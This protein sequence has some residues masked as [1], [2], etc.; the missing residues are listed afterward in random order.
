[1]PQRKRLRRAASGLLLMLAL[2]LGSSAVVTWK[3]TRRNVAPFAEPCEDVSWAQI[4]GH[5]L[6]TCDGH[7]IGAWLV[8]GAPEKG[9]VLLLHGNGRCR[10]AMQNVIRILVPEGLTVM[11]I[12]LRTHG[13][14]TGEINDFGLGARHDVV[15]TV[16]FLEAEFPERPIYIVGRSL[17]AAA[18]LFAADDLFVPGA[19]SA[20]DEAQSRVAGYLL[21]QPY[22]DLDSATWNR[23]QRCLP[24][25]LDRVA[26]GGMRCCA[27]ALFP[28]DLAAVAPADH[29][30][31]IPKNVPI[32]FIAGSADAHARLDEVRE[33]YRQVADHARLIVF[34]GAGH[35]DL[36]LYDPDLYRQTLLEVVGLTKGAKTQPDGD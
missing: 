32:T 5:R 3:L 22:T 16:R 26:Y 27:A 12:S 11:S 29:L 19:N 28:V 15:E 6:T 31:S 36:D 25:V 8:R 24:P 2:W 1:M 20:V 18:A 14:S 23:L 34:D 35:V 10:T 21:E 30:S 33:M 17:G 7:Q 4:E 9:C 13:D